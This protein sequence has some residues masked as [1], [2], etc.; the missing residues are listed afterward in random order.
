MKIGDNKFIV[1]QFRHLS[2]FGAHRT[3]YRYANI[4]I[5]TQV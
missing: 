3:G 5:S 1:D 4:Q 2:G